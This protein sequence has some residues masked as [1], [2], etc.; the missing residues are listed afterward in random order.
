MQPLRHD[1]SIP[2]A[3]RDLDID[4]FRG[5]NLEYMTYGIEGAEKKGFTYEYPLSRDGASQL[6]KAMKKLISGEVFRPS[7]KEPGLQRDYQTLA[8]NYAQM[9]FDFGSEGEVLELLA[10]VALKR[11]LPENYFVT[12]SLAY[13]GGKS[14]GEL[15][16]LVGRSSDCHI[17]VV[18]EAKLGLRQLSHAHQQ[19][20]RFREFI[21]PYAGGGA[22]KALNLAY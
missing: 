19:L 16:L 10:I 8:D 6:W 14:N 1:E 17:E 5:E 9:D 12:G 21:R 7:F 15:D 18:G 3:C 22:F 13:F 11:Q 4:N 20:Q 2:E